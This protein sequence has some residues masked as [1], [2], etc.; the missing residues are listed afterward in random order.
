MQTTDQKETL[1]GFAGTIAYKAPEVI[2]MNKPTSKVDVWAIG[3]IL[4][5]LLTSKHPFI[6]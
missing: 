5:E 3:I 2:N 4:Y 1:F 6:K